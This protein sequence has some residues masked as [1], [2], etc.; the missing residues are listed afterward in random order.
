MPNKNVGLGNGNAVRGDIAQHTI[1]YGRV[2]INF[3]VRPV[4]RISGGDVDDIDSEWRVTSWEGKLPESGVEI[5]FTFMPK[6][7]G[8]DGQQQMTI[9]AVI[10]G[11]ESREFSTPLFKTGVIKAIT[12]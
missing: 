1:R 5:P 12:S 7:N 11:P 2:T 10:L 4:Y 8:K 6:Q 3:E 9:M